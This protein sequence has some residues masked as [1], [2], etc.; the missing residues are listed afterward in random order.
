MYSILYMFLWLA[1]TVVRI[2][3]VSNCTN[4]GTVETASI[5]PLRLCQFQ[6]CS[7]VSTCK[8]LSI[9]QSQ[10][11]LAPLLLGIHVYKNDMD[12]WW[13]PPCIDRIVSSPHS[14]LYFSVPAA[15]LL[16]TVQLK[17]LYSLFKYAVQGCVFPP[18]LLDWFYWHL[19]QN[20]EA[21]HRGVFLHIC[22]VVI[23][24]AWQCDTRKMKLTTCGM[25]SWIPS[26]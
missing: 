8:N 4:L 16:P 18:D 5:I 19:E 26:R 1:Y 11:S 13:I 3:G 21:R 14:M 10:H 9:C 12:R 25:L 15:E 20:L 23:W 6:H 7:K 2:C 17:V 22:T 24:T